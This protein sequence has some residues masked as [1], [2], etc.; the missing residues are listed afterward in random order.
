MWFLLFT[1]YSVVDVKKDIQ[2]IFKLPR[3]SLN[4]VPMFNR[5][6]VRRSFIQNINSHIIIVTLNIVC[7]LLQVSIANIYP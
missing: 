3:K 1:L 4:D 2:N 7:Y 6:P 5:V